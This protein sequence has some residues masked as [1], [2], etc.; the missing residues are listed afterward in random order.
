MQKVFL[1]LQALPWVF[2]FA[3]ALMIG[4]WVIFGLT[5]ANSTSETASSSTQMVIYIILAFAIIFTIMLII[6]GIVLVKKRKEQSLSSSGE[7]VD[8]DN[9][10]SVLTSPLI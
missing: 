6:T 8:H 7:Q 5:Y 10:I 9:P 2:A 4:L 1:R 3:F